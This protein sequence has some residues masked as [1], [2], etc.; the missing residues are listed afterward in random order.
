M[1]F[2]TFLGRIM[3]CLLDHSPIKLLIFGH[4]HGLLTVISRS[5][6]LLEKDASSHCRGVNQNF[7]KTSNDSFNIFYFSPALYA[8]FLT[9]PS[10]NYA[11]RSQHTFLAK[12]F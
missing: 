9:L 12:R 6:T 11:N 3:S 8:K 10:E 7:N 5:L 4:V 2:D 1:N